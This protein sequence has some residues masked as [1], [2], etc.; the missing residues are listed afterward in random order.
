MKNTCFILL[1]ICIAIAS[2]KVNAQSNPEDAIIGKRMTVQ[3]NLKV[4]VYKQD[5]T[6]KAKILW[7]KDSDD[8][9]RPMESRLDDKNPDESLRTRKWIGMEVLRDLSYNAEDKE[10]ENGK[11]Y[12][13]KN[14]KEWDSVAWI[15][16]DNFLKVKGYWLFKFLCQ[17]LTFKKVNE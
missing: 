6:F 11:V 4:E 5:N 7:F 3:N 8:K 15:T 12:V 9:N 1:L 14:G 10:W 13:A 2:F 17:T 16:E